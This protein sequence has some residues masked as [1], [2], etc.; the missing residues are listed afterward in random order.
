MFRDEK[1]VEDEVKAWD[2]WHSRQHS[3]KHRVMDIGECV[4][5]VVKVWSRV[6]SRKSRSGSRDWSMERNPPFRPNLFYSDNLNIETLHLS[7][8]LCL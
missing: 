4:Q 7:S 8:R 5:G 1:T 6:W 3:V 2:F